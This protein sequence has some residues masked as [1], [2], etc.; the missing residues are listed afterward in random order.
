MRHAIQAL[1]L[2][3]SMLSGCSLARAAADDLSP[4]QPV[5]ECK[6]HPCILSAIFP[7][8]IGPETQTGVTGWLTKVHAAKADHL[9]VVIDS[10]GGS[11]DA[12]REIIKYFQ[13]SAIPFT[14]V[15]KTTAASAA[16]WFYEMCP[17]RVVLASSVLMS[18]E[19]SITF[20]NAGASF[21][22]KELTFMAATVI[23][24]TLE[25][26]RDVSSRMGVSGDEILKRWSQGSW[27]VNGETA[28]KLRMADRM[29]GS[30]KELTHELEARYR[31]D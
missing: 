9:L 3:V 1:I 2:A 10:P 27:V 29:V 26:A 19:T 18:H 24:N 6:A 14:C 15:A 21:T 23:T 20:P 11:T 4:P 17:D 22:A 31:H 7:G 12:T 8:Y 28:V 25:M 16:F 30:I 5:V 13:A